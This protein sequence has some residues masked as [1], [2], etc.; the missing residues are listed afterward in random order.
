MIWKSCLNEIFQMIDKD[1]EINKLKRRIAGLERT[2]QIVSGYSSRIEYNQKQLFQIV[3]ETMPVPMLISSEAGE[4]V[5]FNGK[6]QEIFGYSDNDFHLLPGSALYEDANV[7]SDFLK[8]LAESGEVRNFAVNLKKADGSVFPASF[9]SKSL[10]FEG[11]NC[12]LTVIHDLSE[13][14]KE[15]KKRLAIE[16]QIRQTQKMEAI[17]T[18]AG[19]IAH[20]FNNVLTVIFGNSELAMMMLPKDCKARSNIGNV[21]TAAN[22]AKEMIKQ[23]MAFSRKSE[24][25]R[26]PFNIKFI[27]A[28]VAKMIESMTPSNIKIVKQIESKSSI[29]FGDPTQI[30]QILM[31][32]CSNANYALKDRGDTIEIRLK[33]VSINSREELNIPNLRTGNYV[34]LTVCDNG[35]GMDRAVIERIFEPFFTTKPI[36]E[37]TGMGLAVVHG[38][39]KAH[40]G[41]VTVESL[42]GEGTA[43]HCFFPLVAH[44]E[45]LTEESAGSNKAIPGGNE[46]ILL[47]DD[48]STILETYNHV[49]TDLGYQVTIRADSIEALKLFRNNPDLFDLLVADE[50]M[51]KLSGR[52]MTREILKTRTDIP[53]VM[54][55][56][57]EIDDKLF[58]EIG[59]VAIIR[60]PFTQHE[61]A[62]AVRGAL[63]GKPPQ[64]PPTEEGR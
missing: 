44:P 38:I 3:S 4:I 6:A 19:G 63:D 57:S 29:I 11:K 61:L 30:H 15:E 39:V 54:I 24:E 58:Y 43:F 53:V 55:T 37:G 49:L 36:G 25:E 20:D 33:E 31:N 51:P 35:P 13:I 21:L 41:T 27:V 64:S 59:A 17:G 9:F 47:V 2:L 18:M 42:P 28:E 1:K 52:E 7:R 32:L 50:T 23:I 5:F 56:G 34:R 62:T 12:L 10:V 16:N 14:R 46:K 60:K 45:D 40:G 26:K 22:R 8:M 48:D